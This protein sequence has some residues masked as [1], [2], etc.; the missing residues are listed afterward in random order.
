MDQND[1]YTVNHKTVFLHTKTHTKAMIHPDHG[2]TVRPRARMAL[3]QKR[4]LGPKIWKVL[5]NDVKTS[6][7]KFGLE[8]MISN[9][10]VNIL[11]VEMATSII[12]WS[13]IRIFYDL[14]FESTVRA[15]DGPNWTRIDYFC[16]PGQDQHQDLK[17]FGGC[18]SLW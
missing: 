1:D 4:R 17:N 3:F 13:K 16:K 11:V 7:S 12:F 15:L 18:R 9:L 2:R 10:F 14:I 8:L 6:I 5:G